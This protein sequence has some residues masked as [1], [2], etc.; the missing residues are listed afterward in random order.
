VTPDDHTH[1]RLQ[2]IENHLSNLDKRVSV[3]SAVDDGV[4]KQRIRETFGDPRTVIIYRGVERGMTQ[5]QIAAALKA[6]KLP[7]ADQPAVSR[8]LSDLEEKQ[9]VR[10]TAAGGYILREGWEDFGLARTLKKTLRD[11][12]IDDLS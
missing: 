5:K 3:L 8:T 6:R 12:N 10:K 2:R 4:V 11:A 9:F 1:A 7:L